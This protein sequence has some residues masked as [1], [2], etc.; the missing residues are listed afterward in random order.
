MGT[1]E[2]V[3]FGQ[4]LQRE[5]KQ[6]EWT[7]EELARQIAS[8]YNL[9]ISLSSIHRW[10]N[11]DAIPHP[12]TREKVYQLFG[13][14]AATWGITEKNVAI[15]NVPF[16]RNLHFTGREE[17]LALIH[18]HISKKTPVALC[19]LGGI[20]KTQTTVEY[21]YR[22]GDACDS[23]LWIRA[24]TL[25]SLTADVLAIAD[26]LHIAEK[27]EKNY[28]NVIT[29]FKHWLQ[30]HTSWLLIF[31]N[32]D[33]IDT[34]SEFLSLRHGGAILLT[35]RTQRIGRHIKRIEMVKLSR[36][37]SV[38]L[39]FH[40]THQGE[41]E[42]TMDK[43]A[44]HERDAAEKLDALMEG[45]PLALDQAAAYIEETQCSISEYL[46]LYQSHPARLLNRTGTVN[47]TEYPYSVATTW[48]LSFQHIQQT[49]TA[50]V[51]LLSLCAFLHPDAIPMEIITQ[52]ML[53]PGSPLQHIAADT[54]ELNE[55]IG[56]LR[57]YSLLRRDP[58]TKVLTIHRL[59][60]TVLKQNMSQE[61]Y[62]QWV[63]R[64]IHAVNATFPTGEFGNWERCEYYLPHVQVCASLIEQHCLVFSEAADLLHRAGH[65]LWTRSRF[66]EAEAILQQALKMREEIYGP[67]QLE[68]AHTVHA[69]GI[70]FHDLSHYEQSEQLLRRTLAIRE[71]HLGMYHV[72]VA[73]TLMYLS[74]LSSYFGRY[75]ETEA[76]LQ[77]ALSIYD[78][79]L[80]RQHAETAKVLVELGALYRSLDRR[81]ETETVWREALSIR[82][83]LYGPDHPDVADSLNDLGLICMEQEKM[84]EAEELLSQA[85]SRLQQLLG[86]HHSLT[87]AAIN[88]LAQVYKKLGRYADAERL[89]LQV[90]S[91][92]EQILEPNHMNFV[93]IFNHLIMLYH[94]QGR[95]EDA[96]PLLERVLIIRQNRAGSVG[97]RMTAMMDQLAATYE[98]LPG[99]SVEDNQQ[100]V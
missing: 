1:V 50:A 68:T 27:E 89:W 54:P 84:E 4:G 20:G 30:T 66:L 21:A 87:V 26:L 45:L 19:G 49:S 57:N 6:R 44:A 17:I 88:N 93:N 61:T 2:T 65:Y 25:D 52:G 35:T 5:R 9:H 64:A 12:A 46:A 23:I 76:I 8:A 82:E 96:R 3:S 100:R 85:V 39:L 79:S 33:N 95:Y 63:E 75:E 55:T 22:Y 40:H 67:D 74:W 77:R 11:D 60:Q 97:P 43:M 62:M 36:E 41:E 32:A 37:E 15:W 91:I 29:A 73:E 90:L 80:G 83:H 71:R 42:Q 81:T 14:T 48:T 13:K 92:R 69:L 86:V 98:Q 31:D 47:T 18:K 16:A 7:Q 72:Q 28:R 94:E 58:E 34:I 24:D 56:I 99:A 70:V 51:N 78:Q 38:T 10:E 53:Q 59:V